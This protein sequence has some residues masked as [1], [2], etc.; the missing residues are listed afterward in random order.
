MRGTWLLINL[1]L[2]GTIATHSV[3]QTTS[4]S[5]PQSMQSARQAIA[6]SFDP[7]AGAYQ[8][9]KIAVRR[10]STLEPNSAMEQS[11]SGWLSRL[12]FGAPKTPKKPGALE[13][14]ARTK[15]GA[16]L[17]IDRL[18]GSDPDQVPLI[19]DGVGATVGYFKYD[20]SKDQLYRIAR[21]SFVLFFAGPQ[22]LIASTGEWICKKVESAGTP[23]LAFAN[24]RWIEQE[25]S[26]LVD[27]RAN[28]GVV[29]FF[30]GGTE[31]KLLN[32][33]GLEFKSALEANSKGYTE[34]GA[35]FMIE[36]GAAGVPSSIT[37]DRPKDRELRACI[38]GA[39]RLHDFKVC[40][41]D[42]NMVWTA[43]WKSV[44]ENL[45]RE[46][47]CGGGRRPDFAD[48][49]DDYFLSACETKPEDKNQ[50][51]LDFEIAHREVPRL[52]EFRL[53]CDCTEL[54]PSRFQIDVNKRT[55]SFNIRGN[56]E[57]IRF[58][59]GALRLGQSDTASVGRSQ[60][61]PLLTARFNENWQILEIAL[62]SNGVAIPA[63][64]D[65]QK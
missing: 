47:G 43:I 29:E 37:R 59:G 46:V 36:I 55:I 54:V 56:A 1:A 53:S 52:M 5:E 63:Q 4:P 28:C 20:Q 23:R 48:Q 17:V 38:A 9:I 19:A 62:S 31:S 61:I 60:T 32:L 22:G 39:K 30:G 11:S 15:A 50:I 45:E 49:R 13:V 57:F 14:V 58:E 21:G 44:S 16:E 7:A 34:E 41:P 8:P 27:V 33:T 40:G 35:R 65:G 26:L 25:R 24:A 64:S 10:A 12:G 6:T 18:D 42:E 3:A 2:L 51:Y